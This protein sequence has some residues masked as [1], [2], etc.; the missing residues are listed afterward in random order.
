MFKITLLFLLS[1]FFINCSVNI[2]KDEDLKNLK[3]S[4]GKTVEVLY[5]KHTSPETGTVFLVECST[6]EKIVKDETVEKDILEIW[7]KFEK[8]AN[9]QELDEA[10]IK[11]SF[12]VEDVNEKGEPEKTATVIIFTGEKIENGKWK[13]DKI[14]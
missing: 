9:E 2:K 1:I 6:E 4:S 13:I 5:E 11:Y 14:G 3:L 12:I 7:S 8:F 10:I